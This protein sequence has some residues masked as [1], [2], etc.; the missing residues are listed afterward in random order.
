[1]TLFHS[2]SAFHRNWSRTPSADVERNLLKADNLP[3]HFQ[4]IY[5]AP[6][7]SYLTWTKNISTGTVTFLS[8]LAGYQLATSMSF[9]NTIQ[10]IDISILLSNETDLYYFAA[11]FVLIN[12]AIRAFVATFPLRIYKSGKK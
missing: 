5:R 4:L 7:E 12:L 6:M 8:I 2:T 1:M 3:Q 10:K 11:G 9:I